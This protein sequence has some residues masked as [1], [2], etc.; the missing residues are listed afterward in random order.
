[1]QK[2]LII[3]SLFIL[4]LGCS[5]TFDTSN[6][7]PEDRLNYA[8]KLYEQRDYQEAADEFQALI[9][10][11]PGSSIVDDAQYY[12]GM[13]R[14]QKREYILAAF[15]FSRLIRNMSASEY[16]P[17]AQFMLAESY[18][19]LS[20]DVNLDQ[21]YSKK[22][23]EEYQAFIDFFP[24]HEKVFE[25]EKK[26][27]ELNYKL[28]K[29]EFDTARIYDKLEYY[30]ASIKYYDNVMEIYHD[31]EFAPLAMYNKIL[32]LEKR[33]QNDKALEEAVKFIE[34]YPDHPNFQNVQSFK[35][36][37]EKKLSASK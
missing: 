6:M 33:K 8:I 37:L 32:I 11:Y 15:E 19:K 5:S 21:S 27:K 30:S 35:T 3:S 29:K 23:I 9:L 25:A 36:G 34:K 20:P 22:A 12:L 24:L 1:M 14:Y 2:I 10:Q 7:T 26:M 4:L 18:Y 17:L 16:L 31:T 28:A 13:A